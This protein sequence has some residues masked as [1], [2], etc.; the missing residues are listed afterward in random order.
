METKIGILE[1][2]IKKNLHQSRSKFSE[3]QP[4]TPLLF[5]EGRKKF[6]KRWN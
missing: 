1:I 6:W 2:R 4:G 5:L 3:E